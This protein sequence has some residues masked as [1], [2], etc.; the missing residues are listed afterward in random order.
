MDALDDRLRT[1]SGV[2]GIARERVDFIPP[3]A[4]RGRT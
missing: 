2:I 1:I 3:A 4:L